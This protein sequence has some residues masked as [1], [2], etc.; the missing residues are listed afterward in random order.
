MT[1]ASSW[2]EV[3]LTDEQIKERR[4][5]WVEEHR[6]AL[7]MALD[8]FLETG[9]WPERERFRRQ[10]VQR[11]IDENVEQL[12]STM[13]RPPWVPEPIVPERVVLPLVVL[14]LMPQAESLL[15]ACA[16]MVQRAYA[17]YRTPDV[18]QPV[19]RSDDPDL[20][21]AVGGDAMLL[22]LARDV[23]DSSRPGVLGGGQTSGSDPT[24]WQAYLNEAAMPKFA[25]IRTI[26]DFLAAQVKIM[27][28]DQR[29]YRSRSGQPV[30]AT[31]TEPELVE[32]F[33][34]MPFREPWSDQVYSFIGR[35]TDRIGAPDG[36]FRLYR[37]D[38]I[39]D[40]G[41]IT[42]QIEDAIISAHAIVADITGTNGNVMWE[43]GYAHALGK[44]AVI[45]NQDPDGSPFDLVDRRQ[46]VYTL[47][48]TEVDHPGNGGDPCAWNRWRVFARH[49]RCK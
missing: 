29:I 36:T 15:Q 16:A 27:D 48:F 46:Y 31:S 2:G 40:P 41:R 20:R 3:Y 49:S 21:A 24:E 12:L 39:G 25:D 42:Q 30:A 47:E 10:L 19:L 8:A 35:A 4:R 37:A 44:Q 26:D 7:D 22:R 13:P 38:D 33:V 5:A 17:L 11:G 18:D 34:L 23:L 9:K 28:E 32:V 43:L 45:L 1:G 6:P 14:R